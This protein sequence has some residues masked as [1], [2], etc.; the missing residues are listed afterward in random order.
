MA[1]KKNKKVINNFGHTCTKRSCT[2]HIDIS[3][4]EAQLLHMCHLL[5]Q[6]Q[7]HLLFVLLQV[8]LLRLQSLELNL[9][10]RLDLLHLYSLVPAASDTHTHTRAQTEMITHVNKV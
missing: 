2:H 3:V 1:V 8:L 7:V 9:E 5:L 10:T 4:D 6:E